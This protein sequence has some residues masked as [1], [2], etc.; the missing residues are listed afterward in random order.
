MLRVSKLL[1]IV[2]LCAALVRLRELLLL[3]P[4]EGALFRLRQRSPLEDLRKVFRE[5]GRRG[6]SNL[7]LDVPAG[8]LR[9]YLLQV[10]CLRWPAIINIM[11][12]IVPPSDFRI[13]SELAAFCLQF[14]EG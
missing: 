12:D 7:M 14:S 4:A 3:S 6:E 2:S 8:H 5:V 9:E 10:G 13:L 1:M 11:T